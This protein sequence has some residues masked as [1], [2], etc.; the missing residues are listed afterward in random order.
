[1]QCCIFKIKA[2]LPGLTSPQTL[3]NIHFTRAH[4][5]TD[6]TQYTFYQGSHLHRHYTIYILPGL[7]SAQT[8]H[9]IYFTS[10]HIC[11]DT[12]QYIFYQGSHL[13]RHYTIYIL[14]VLTSSQTLH[15][16]YFTSSHIFTDTTQY[17]FYQGS[18]LH[19]HYTIHK[20]DYKQAHSSVPVYIWNEATYF[21][22]TFEYNHTFDL[23]WFDM[24][25]FN[26]HNNQCLWCSQLGQ[27]SVCQNLS[28]GVATGMCHIFTIECVPAPATWSSHIH[29]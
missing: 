28:H 22:L 11:T 1:M 14:P 15:N 19:R 29:V 7:T 5:C 16:I 23:R 9:N 2:V 20:V 13:H 26:C 10:S 27:F 6:T 17:I 18:H 3:H 21:W 12:I 4:I 24:T 8:L 25:A